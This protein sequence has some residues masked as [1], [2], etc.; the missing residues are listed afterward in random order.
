MNDA[1]QSPK[2]HQPRQLTLGRRVLFA[3]ATPIVVF[4]LKI[5]WLTYRFRLEEDERFTELAQRGESVVIAFWHE[6]IMTVG[7]YA[8]RLLRQ[9]VRMT[10][11][12]SPSADGELGTMILASFGS[13]AVRG[14]A[15]R[16][17]AAALRGLKCAIV[18]DRQTPA[19]AIDG[20]KG[21]RRYCKPGAIM[22]ARMAGV[23]IIPVGFAARRGWRA[24]TWDRHLVPY[25][26]SKVSITVGEP[27]VVEREMDAETLEERR[28]ELEDRVNQLMEIS[29]AR[30]GVQ[31]EAML[32]SAGRNEEDV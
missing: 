32:A 16:S 20:S 28:R 15:R 18:E 7:W 1:T 14:S 26:G 13:R 27:F 31:T 21:P 29:E 22:V 25:P 2:S 8:A 9:G 6:G 23:P 5:A 12:I 3:I 10:F 19:I 11:L 24:P 4:I 17:G 30:V